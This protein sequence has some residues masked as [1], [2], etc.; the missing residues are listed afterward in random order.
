MISI[1]LITYLEE[2]ALTCNYYFNNETLHNSFFT[3]QLNY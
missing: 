3:D 1:E 2:I